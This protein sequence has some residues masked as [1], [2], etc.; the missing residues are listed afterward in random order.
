MMTWEAPVL[1]ETACGLEVTAYT[2]AEGAD[3]GDII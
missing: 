3:E 2:S 1:S